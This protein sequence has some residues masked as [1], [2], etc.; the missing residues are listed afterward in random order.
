MVSTC[1]KGFIHRPEDTCVS[2]G[3]GRTTSKVGSH[4]C[5]CD[6]GFYGSFDSYNTQPSCTQ[7]PVAT[8]TLSVGSATVSSC[9]CQSGYFG[10]NQIC[11]SCSLGCAT[12]NDA[13]STSC[14]SCTTGYLYSSATGTCIGTNTLL[15]S[16]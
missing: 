1:D 10:S 7:C 11:Q 15:T 6:V 3:T 16:D 8:T 9:V 14:T 2:C 13:S 4:F 5:V 12:C